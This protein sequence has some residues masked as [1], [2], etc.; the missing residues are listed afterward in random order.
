MSVPRSYLT[1]GELMTEKLETINV[2]NT[3]QEAAAKMTDKN[4]SSL[5]VVDDDGR[6]AG[7]VTERDFVRRI[8]AID[9][10][11]S[12]VK[13]QE[14]TSSPVK[15]VNTGTSIGEAADIMVRN[16]IRHILV[17]DRDYKKPIGIVSTTDIVA[18]VR[19]NSETMRQV[20]K[21]VLEALE[22]EGRF[23]F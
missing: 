23:Y 1:I 8:C 22:K 12:K 6:P 4:I 5:A 13:V 14:I 11:S 17:T 18:Y 7:I 10:P 16:K 19:E 15:T 21:D 20:D 2:L 9:K 3:A